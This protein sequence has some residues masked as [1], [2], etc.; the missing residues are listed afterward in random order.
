MKDRSIL[1]AD[2]SLMTMSGGAVRSNTIDTATLNITGNVN[3]VEKD[4]GW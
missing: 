4:C 3:S 1:F 2:G